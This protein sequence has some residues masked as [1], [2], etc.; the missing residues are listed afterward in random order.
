MS[1]REDGELLVR[2]DLAAASVAREDAGDVA[3]CYTEEMEDMMEK[4][5]NPTQLA[6]VRADF[7][8]LLALGGGQE[9]DA[10]IW[11]YLDRHAPA[12]LK[13]QQCPIRL[14]AF[15]ACACKT[16]FNTV[17]SFRRFVQHCANMGGRTEANEP[18]QSE[19][20]RECRYHLVLF[21]WMLAQDNY[22]ADLA[23]ELP[24]SVPVP[25]A[26]IPPGIADAAAPP[27]A[28]APAAAPAAEDAPPPAKRARSEGP[29]GAAPDDAE[30]F[31]ARLCDAGDAAF[32]S[33]NP[34]MPCR[35]AVQVLKSPALCTA[36]SG[37]GRCKTW[38]MREAASDDASGFSPAPGNSK[39]TQPRRSP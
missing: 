3:M 32:E 8:E 7:D 15:K 18:L 16:S 23:A 31:A 36:K 35:C 2:G 24:A 27:P 6:S 14:G 17:D 21:Q 1:M 13:L 5:N 39:A 9:T 33:D 25:R 12:K 4:I 37:K 30:A 29:D 19:H 10:G 22:R 26:E 38:D 28:A 34:D 11:R 20:G